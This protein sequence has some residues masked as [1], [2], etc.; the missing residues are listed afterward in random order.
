[1]GKAEILR[2]LRE[3]KYQ[4]P[5]VTKAELEQE[6]KQVQ[7]KKGMKRSTPLKRKTVKGPNRKSKP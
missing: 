6:I 5:V 7:S 1:M 2:S 4:Q 3:A